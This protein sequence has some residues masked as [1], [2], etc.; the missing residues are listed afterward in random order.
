MSRW[1]PT[2][3]WMAIIWMLSARGQSGEDSGYLL[4]GLL[5]WLGHPEAA[6]PYA[7]LVVHAVARKLA[8]F[9]AF[10]VLA[11]LAVRATGGGRPLH[12]WGLA[13]AWAILDEWHQS[14]VPGRSG[15]ARDVMI[16]AAGATWAMWGRW[17]HVR[18]SRPPGRPAGPHPARDAGPS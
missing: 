13:V 4:A 1:A 5:A 2:L 12:A 17:I 8:H 15:N 18:L 3:L 9:G 7:R 16:D 6:D 11:L 10:A 14:F